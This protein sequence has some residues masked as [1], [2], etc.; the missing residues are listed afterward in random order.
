MES[1]NFEEITVTNQLGNRGGYLEID[2]TTLGYKNCKMRAI[3]NYLGGGILGRVYTT[4]NIS[5]VE[6]EANK[7]LEQIS[8]QLRKY[9]HGL[10]NQSEGCY[11]YLTFE[12]NQNMPIT[13]Y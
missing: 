6:F 1:I 7:E 5:F 13:A 2:L 12:Q 9:V 8:Q 10:T 11:E 4:H 3:Q